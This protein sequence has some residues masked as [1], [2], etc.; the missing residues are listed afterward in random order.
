MIKILLDECL[1]KNRKYR[2]E[3]LDQDF[4]AKSVPEVGWGRL[5]NGELLSVAEQEYDLFETS[6]K[7]LSFQQPLITASIQVV[8]LIA[9]TNTYEDLLPLCEKL[10]PIIRAHEPCK[11]IEIE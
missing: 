9:K 10:S 5:R 4:V 1:P 11:F 6:D 3:E 8:L 7:N 2:I